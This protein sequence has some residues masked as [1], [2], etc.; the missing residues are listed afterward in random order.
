MN[1]HLTIVAVVVASACAGRAP[2]PDNRAVPPA[3]ELTVPDDG[4]RL[5][6]AGHAEGV[7][8]YGCSTRADGGHEWK[9]KA[10]DAQ[11]TS[12]SGEKLRHYGG[13]TWEAADG[14]KV[15][16]EVKA[17]EQIDAAAVPWLLL[18]AK[19]NSGTGLLAKARWIQRA[20]TVGGKAPADGCDDPHAGAEA[21]IAYSA[22]YRLWGD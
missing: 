1:R 6:F 15:V 17:H 14:S 19:S 18:S 11:V 21:R 16:G 2:Q 10:P 7:Q 20:N 8:I 22:V 9:L 12:A 4:T 5:I 3:V 13:P